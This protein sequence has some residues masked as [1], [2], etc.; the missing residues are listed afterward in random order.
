MAAAKAGTVANFMRIAPN[1]LTILRLA[2]ALP[3]FYTLTQLPDQA[4]LALI[5]LIAAGATD[6]LDGFVARHFGG[7]S[8][9]GRLMDPAVDKILVCGAFVFLIGAPVNVP[10]W[11]VV[12]ILARELGVTALRAVAEA[13]GTPYPGTIS[14]KIK[15]FTEFVT[16]CYAIIYG[17]QL[18]HTQWPRNVL[19]A[20]LIATLAAVLI[21]GALHVVR[22][23][24]VIRAE[25]SDQTQP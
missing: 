22:S 13:Q 12:V 5:F 10:A 24:K 21:S 2:L 17:G 25:P 15:M 3:L 9:F 7:Q 1:F 23:I 6:L 16:L 11:V 20:L 8:V 4:Y 19:W 18:F 14:G